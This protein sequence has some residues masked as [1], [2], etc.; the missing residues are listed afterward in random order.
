[1]LVRNGVI[2]K[3]RSIPVPLPIENWNNIPDREMPALLLSYFS[4]CVTSCSANRSQALHAAAAVQGKTCPAHLL[5]GPS[6]SA[7]ILSWPSSHQQPATSRAEGVWNSLDTLSSQSRL[8]LPLHPKT[9]NKICFAA[10]T[11]LTGLALSMHKACTSFRS[12]PGQ[13]LRDVCHKNEFLG[14][15]L[16]SAM[17]GWTPKYSMH[18]PSRS[19][20]IL[21]FPS[22]DLLAACKTRLKGTSCTLKQED[23]IKNKYI[24]KQKE[25]KLTELQAVAKRCHLV[26]KQDLNKMNST[27][28]KFWWD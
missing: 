4:Q 14:L 28:G 8:A 26:S 11:F 17:V 23:S 7:P 22:S 19:D 12:A 25:N 20:A 27:T 2:V 10:I 9:M 21:T 18:L 15:I 3:K 5:Q 1:M 6:F 24:Q 16:I 13:E